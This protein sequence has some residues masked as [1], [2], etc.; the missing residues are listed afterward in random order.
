MK[1]RKVFVYC[2][3]TLA[4]IALLAVPS[5]QPVRSANPSLGGLFRRV[6]THDVNGA[7]AEIVAAT[8]DGR[9]LIYTN[10][11]DDKLVL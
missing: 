10:S 1:S 6:A 11:A 2:F 7:V 8:T 4:A 5:V 3:A 9:T